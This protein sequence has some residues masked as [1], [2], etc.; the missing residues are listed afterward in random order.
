MQGYHIFPSTRGVYLAKNHYENYSPQMVPMTPYLGPSSRSNSYPLL[1]IYLFCM[2]TLPG[3]K[4]AIGSIIFVMSH[5][6]WDEGWGE[7]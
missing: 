2:E 4:M 1:T 5:Y 7:L 6:I 3:L